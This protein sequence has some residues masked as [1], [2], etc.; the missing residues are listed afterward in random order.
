MSLRLLSLLA[1]VLLAVAGNYAY[2]S[3]TN[4]PQDAGPDVPGGKVRSVSFAPFRGLQS[5]LTKSYPT[6]QEIEEDLALLAG[7]VR[8]IRTY[9]SREGMEV[10]P[11]MARRHGIKITMG[12][13]LGGE[14]PINRKE[15]ES[16]VHLANTYPDVIERVIV[17]NEVLLR[18]DL[19]PDKLLAYIREVKSRVKQPVSYAD[20]WAFHLKHPQIGRELDYVT[21][22]ILP[23]WEDEPAHIDHVGP[24][25]MHYYQKV[26][27]AF[28][29][30]PILIGEAGWPTMGR[31]RG[32]AEP[33]V[34]NS[35]KFVRTLIQVADQNGFDYNVVEA[36]DQPWKAA[37]EGTVGAKWGLWSGDR[38]PVFP[39][40]GPVVEH[41]DW[42]ARFLLSSLV[43]L[44]LVAPFARRLGNAWALPVVGLAQVLA[45]GLVQYSFVAHA[46]G[47]SFW[48][49]FNFGIIPMLLAAGFAV[50]LVVFAAGVVER[51]V[52][53][54][55]GRGAN[56]LAAWAPELFRFFSA[57][58]ALLAA[59][60]I[61]DG[62][63]RDIPVLPFLVP[64]AG[65][66][67]LA[68]LRLATGRDSLS[69]FS[70]W[71]VFG[72]RPNWLTRILARA[73]PVLAGF[74]LIAE[75]WAI[76]GDDFVTMHPTLGEQV[77]L[78]LTAMVS[79]PSVLIWSA[80]LL[81]LALPHF[82]DLVMARRTG[83]QPGLQRA[84]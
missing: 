72:G 25:I 28:P 71:E 24:H 29:D 53:A 30:K 65:V 19:S 5:P 17:G 40:A 74:N 1:A 51:A 61:L 49:K 36:F 83:L 69:A 9:T 66:L 31:S 11:D 38:E 75:G 57:A 80:M 78:V 12:A 56:G 16:L 10:L 14:D 7:R 21:I 13:W 79:N 55:D 54:V 63:Y 2:W 58:A 26:H 4:Q 27:D 37:L 34:V 44:G 67:G 77:P 33:G 39:L 81:G 15:I 22:H 46:G 84:R 18:N 52:G 8:G 62:R 41:P 45:V 76:T 20:V 42:P 3:R 73:L 48:A 50:A 82:A 70:A 64:V 68:V 43:M 59:L 47:I 35:A 32:P 60:I 23:F 6:P